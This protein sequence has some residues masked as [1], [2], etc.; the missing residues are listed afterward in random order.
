MSKWMLA[1]MTLWATLPFTGCA[2]CSAPDD[3]AYAAYGGVFERADRCCG[4]VFSAFQPA[5]I[6]V[7]SAPMEG[8]L[9]SPEEALEWEA[10]MLPLES[11]NGFA[12]PTDGSPGP[13]GNS[14]EP[15]DGL[16][17]ALDG[18]AESTQTIEPDMSPILDDSGSLPQ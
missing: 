18:A 4:R 3:G 1:G 7:D 13:T 6:V 8:E 15:T 10:E 14:V 2:I 5:G 9:L 12:E 17:E 11:A 16:P